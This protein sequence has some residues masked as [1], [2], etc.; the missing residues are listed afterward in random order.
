MPTAQGVSGGLNE[1]RWVNV[2]K[3]VDR[4]SGESKCF[5]SQE[6]GL[7]NHSL[8]GSTPFWSFLVT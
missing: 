5:E 8:S 4:S 2:Y 3:V 1:I 7:W 6:H